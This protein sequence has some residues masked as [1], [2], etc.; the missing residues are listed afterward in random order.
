MSAKDVSYSLHFFFS[1]TQG[2]FTVVSNVK[3]NCFSLIF[4][5]HVKESQYFNFYDIEHAPR[6]RVRQFKFVK[7]I[8]RVP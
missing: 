5:C 3:F 8:K 4:L 1:E 2:N 6:F 7:G